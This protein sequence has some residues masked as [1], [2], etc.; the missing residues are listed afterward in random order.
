MARCLLAAAAR[1]ARL[2][3]AGAC[4]VGLGLSG[5]GSLLQS[6]SPPTTV[7]LL[8]PAAAT[9]GPAVAAD[10]KIRKPHVRSGLNT[11]L[12]VAL[13]PDRHLD[14]F[15]GAAWS[16]PVD[17]VVMDLALQSFR[18]G[19]NL[20][21]VVDAGAPAP[22]SYW[23]D[24]DVLDFQAEYGTA[25]AP[26]VR[27]RLLARLGDSSGQVLGRFEAD[28]RRAAKENRLSAIVEA[29]DQSAGAALAQIVSSCSLRLAQTP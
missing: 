16:G 28:E 18:A 9:P 14:H 6:H 1:G 17:E 20:R 22:G 27:V 15:A 4:L 3:I 29:Y 25:T 24:I 26:T 7:Y 10:L 2:G 8:S 12:I 19:A 13:Y 11:D 21:S 23:L 5:C